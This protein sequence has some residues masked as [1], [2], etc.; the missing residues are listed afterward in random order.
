MA[1]RP[2]GKAE[3][4]T[5]RT[6]GRPSPEMAAQI[7]REI[8]EA[9][10]ELFF[11]QG[12]ARTSMAM[13][14]RAAAVS[15]TTIYARYADK[16]QLFRA[17]V[18]SAIEQ[19][20]N[21]PL[22]APAY[23]ECTAIEGLQRFGRTALRNSLA[24]LWSGYERLVFAEGPSFPEMTETVATQVQVAIDYVVRFLE[25]C[26]ARDGFTT[27]DPE[28]LAT[29]YMMALRG[30]YTAALLA[31]REPSEAELDTFVLQLVRSLLPAESAELA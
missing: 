27:K 26:S 19:I 30:Y 18:A 28:A 17:T 5:G 10:R 13:I 31:V 9:A 6:R 20:A 16:A 4:P 29:T 24:P 21:E 14:V 11:A 3:Q 12:Y 23:A 8:L 25:Q 2:K 1:K 7:D 22:T 15:K